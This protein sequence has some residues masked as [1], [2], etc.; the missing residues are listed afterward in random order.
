MSDTNLRPFKGYQARH[1]LWQP[2][3]DGRVATLR[4]NRPEKKN[5]LTFV[6]YAELRLDHRLFNAPDMMQL[7]VMHTNDA[8]DLAPL[9]A[10][11]VEPGLV[12]FPPSALQPLTPS[13]VTSP[14]TPPPNRSFRC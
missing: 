8:P 3:A 14:P 10:V 6:S 5:P 11:P 7:M 4:L 12:E 13:S 2:S 9:G 1:F